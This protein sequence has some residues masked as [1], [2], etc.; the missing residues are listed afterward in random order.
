MNN[1]EVSDVR[2]RI[3][4]LKLDSFLTN[5]ALLKSVCF[6]YNQREIIFQST[7]I[8]EGL[9]FILEGEIS[10]RSITKEGVEVEIGVL[11]EG[12]F[13][14]DIEFFSGVNRSLHTVFVQDKIRLLK[15]PP[16][17]VNNDLILKPSFLLHMCHSLAEK[18]M[19]TSDNYSKTLLLPANVKVA[20]YILHE[21]QHQGDIILGFSTKK[22]SEK[23]GF[24]DRHVRRIVDEFA[25]SGCI[26]KRGKVVRIID[27]SKIEEISSY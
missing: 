12:G 4:Q 21:F 3:A 24:S 14:G 19:I 10:V 17:V 22:I 20:Q 15:I 5:S 6:T 16:E 25:D 11:N 18:L 1:D 7:D 13:F 2:R 27:I 26:L 23:T 9:Y 8:I